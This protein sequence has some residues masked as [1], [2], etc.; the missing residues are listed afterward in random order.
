MIEIKVI[1]QVVVDLA[2]KNQ[3]TNGMVLRLNS[4]YTE[5]NNIVLLVKGVTNA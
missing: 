3:N 4:N 2:D 1:S 5:T